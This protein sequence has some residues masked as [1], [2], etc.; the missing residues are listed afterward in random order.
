MFEVEETG[1]IKAI[2]VAI[3]PNVFK[4]KISWNLL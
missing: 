3:V 2:T 1:S 4:E